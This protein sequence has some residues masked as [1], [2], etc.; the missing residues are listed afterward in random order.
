MSEKTAG[1]GARGAWPLFVGLPL[2]VAL[3]VA[4]VLLSGERPQP[5]AQEQRSAGKEERAAESGTEPG[6]PFQ[7]DADAPVV[8][9]EYGDFQ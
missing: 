7:G 3:A 9:I 8:M 1:G 5:T 2:I 6:H 4:A